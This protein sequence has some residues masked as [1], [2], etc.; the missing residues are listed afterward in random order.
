MKLTIG[1]FNYSTWSMRPW[2]FIHKHSLPVAVDHYGLSTSEMQEAL[3]ASFSGGKVPVLRDQG[4][5]IWD[6]LAILEYLGER[7][8]ETRPWPEDISARAVA[9]SVSAEM[10]SSFVALRREAPMNLRRRFPGYQLSEAA[11]VDVERIDAVW[12]YCRERF[13]NTGPWLFGEFSIADAMFVP[14]VMRFRSVDVE[15]G[16]VAGHYRRTVEQDP[17][18]REWIRQGLLEDHLVAEDELDWPS[19]PN[20]GLIT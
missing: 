1:D 8:P 9:R 5:E 2:V 20:T 14:V 16:T 12:C 7:F 13:G 10:H 18:V 15:L 17:S 11:V 4:N 3:A 19:E 6:S